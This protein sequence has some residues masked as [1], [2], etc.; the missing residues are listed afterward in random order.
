[1]KSKRTSL[2]QRVYG[3]ET[4]SMLFPFS[5]GKVPSRMDVEYKRD[6]YAS[7]DVS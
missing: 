4:S 3:Q 2:V 1:M 6:F 7:G 5:H